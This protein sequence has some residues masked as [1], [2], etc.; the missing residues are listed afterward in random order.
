[1]T[2]RVHVFPYDNDICIT[3]S[4]TK[5]EIFAAIRVGCWTPTSPSATLTCTPPSPRS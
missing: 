3:C 2:C 1:M 4:R 5:A